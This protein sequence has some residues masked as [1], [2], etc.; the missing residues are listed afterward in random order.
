MGWHGWPWQQIPPG[1]VKVWGVAGTRGCQS[2]LTEARL[3]E[4]P[5]LDR[6]RHGQ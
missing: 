5:G 4:P 6:S 1:N 2:G 3:P